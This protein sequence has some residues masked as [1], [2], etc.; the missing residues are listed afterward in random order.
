MKKLKS[1]LIETRIREIEQIITRVLR[2]HYYSSGK[3]N[4]NRADFLTKGECQKFSKGFRTLWNLFVEKPGEKDLTYFEKTEL[5]SA[6]IF[7][8]LIPNLQRWIHML[9]NARISFFGKSSK[10]ETFSI[11]DYGAGP[12][13]ASAAFL[14]FFQDFLQ[15]K[16]IEIVLSD[17]KAPILKDGQALLNE[18]GKSLNLNIRIKLHSGSGGMSPSGNLSFDFILMGNVWNERL[19]SHKNARDRV[20]KD[21]EINAQKVLK[22]EGKIL[23]QEPASR[24]ASRLLMTI[25]DFFI[26]SDNFKI[27]AP[28]PAGSEKKLCILNS[29]RGRP[30]CHF[31][32][33]PWKSRLM[34][35]ASE[36]SGITHESLHYSYLFLG[37]NG[38]GQNLVRARVIGNPMQTEVGTG[39]YTCHEKGRIVLITPKPKDLPS[40]G[41]ALMKSIL[42]ENKG[43]D[44]VGRFGISEK[45]DS[46]KKQSGQK[47]LQKSRKK[48][49]HDRKSNH[50]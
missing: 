41:K 3:G 24:R 22:K 29:I 17:T 26:E 12:G 42:V 6:Y 4:S 25:R 9:E 48:V 37:F 35:V 39:V 10:T 31:G 27:A 5:R 44:L 43:K 28:C 33:R 2:K 34:Q 13:T 32:F 36:I 8:Y 20:L 50:R 7:H 19:S 38:S 11:L 47:P 45:K 21:F 46:S 15:E 23:L 18:L 30:W 49:K 1:E 14:L 40:S 16:N